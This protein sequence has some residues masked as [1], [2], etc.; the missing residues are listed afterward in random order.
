LEKALRCFEKKLLAEIGY[1]FLF[2]CQLT[3]EKLMSDQWYCFKPDQGFS[4]ASASAAHPK[5][6]GEHLLAIQEDNY[7]QPEILLTAKYLM[8]IAINHL[9]NHQPLKSRELWIMR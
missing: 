6:L 7:T 8:R 4:I 1:G 9:L 5:F 2:E 3:H